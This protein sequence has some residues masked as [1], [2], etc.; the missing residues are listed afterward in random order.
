[1]SRK[2]KSF[3]FF[4]WHRRLGLLALLLVFVLSIT[5]IMLNHTEALK[6]DERTVSSDIL[7]DWYGI[8]PQ[9]PAKKFSTASH[10]LAHWDQQLFLNGE[11]LQTSAQTVHGMIETADMLAVALDQQL[12][13]MDFD[14]ELIEL[15]PLQT[16]ISRIGL[17]ENR[18]ALLDKND[19]FYLADRHI[20]QLH[21]QSIQATQWSDA[22]H[23]EDEQ[24]E[25]LKLLYRGKGL[26][27]E[28]LVLDLHS[29]RLF[30]P[31]WGVYIMDA[32]AIIMMFLGLSGIWVW[33]S[34]KLK[35]RRKKHYRKHH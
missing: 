17:S 3:A 1:M 6:L 14:G 20:S 32:S 28:R 2:K 7:M 11:R 33:W 9:G 15:M 8:N 25:Q 18:L 34:R 35:M 5:G 10:W 16:A 19:Q 22:E 31:T 4:L 13:L 23:V 30:H 12:L 26:D 21:K 27:L 24:L 29:G